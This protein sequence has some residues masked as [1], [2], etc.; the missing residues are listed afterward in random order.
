[1]SERMN[2][3]DKKIMYNF[4]EKLTWKEEASVGWGNITKRGQE[5]TCENL[6][7]SV[8]FQNLVQCQS[9][10][11][12]VLNVQFTQCVVCLATFW[13]YIVESFD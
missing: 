5:N 9:S 11:L 8:E 6:N 3:E 1:M 13:D 4:H 10:V 7:G 2:G 12:A